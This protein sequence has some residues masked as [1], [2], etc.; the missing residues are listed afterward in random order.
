MTGLFQL[1]DWQVDA[2]AA[3]VSL[4]DQRVTPQAKVVEV[5]VYLARH[6]QSTSSSAKD[7]KKVE[8]SSR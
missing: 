7:R 3:A 8:R 5:L 4:G 1:G 6:G 2:Q